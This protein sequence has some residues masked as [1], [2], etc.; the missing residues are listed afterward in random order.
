MRAARVMASSDSDNS[1]TNDESNYE[2]ENVYDSGSEAGDDVGEE[3]EV[4]GGGG[5]WMYEP[6]GQVERPSRAVALPRKQ[7]N[8]KLVSWHS[9]WETLIGICRPIPKTY[10]QT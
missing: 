10:S 4:R 7:T 6:Q 9:D 1:F 3:Q 2:M 5:G 8:V